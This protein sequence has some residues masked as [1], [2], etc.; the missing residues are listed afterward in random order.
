M[1]ENAS[2]RRRFFRLAVG[3][4]LRYALRVGAMIWQVGLL[5]TSSTAA[6]GNTAPFCFLSSL[7]APAFLAGDSR[8]AHL[9]I[10]AEPSEA[11]IDTTLTAFTDNVALRSQ[12]LYVD[13]VLRAAK[14]CH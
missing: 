3:V 5:S 6:R 10:Q 14:L 12:F 13:R 2:C 9:A 8:L 11:L 4:E 1:A 7:R